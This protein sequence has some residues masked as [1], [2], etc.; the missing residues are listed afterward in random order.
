MR[1]FVVN[2]VC[3][4]AEMYEKLLQSGMAVTKE[5]DHLHQALEEAQ[6][7]TEDKISVIILN[8]VTE[9][10]ERQKRECVFP[11]ERNQKILQVRTFGNF[12][13]FY[14]GMP[15]SFRRAKA[16]ELLAYLIDRRGTT[17]TTA[18][19]C[20]ILWEDKEYN[21]SLQRQF[22]T[23]VS[24]LMKSLKNY[25]AEHLIFRRRNCLSV[26]VSGLDCDY[27][28]LMDGDQIIAGQYNG[29]YMSNY[30]WA[31]GT[32]GFLTQKYGNELR[33]ISTNYKS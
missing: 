18:E 27:Y 16:K 7:N 30:S 12:E 15:I 3:D 8:S 2:D 21:F 31:E 19:A 32:A 29:E 5:C 11:G 25:Q 26:D 1:I 14:K 28:K 4:K 9:E 6:A 17:V 13:I 24:E 22:Q 20:A 33:N 10:G 23:I